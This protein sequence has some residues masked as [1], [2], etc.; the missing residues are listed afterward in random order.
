MKQQLTK[1]EVIQTNRNYF[2]RLMN[3]AEPRAF[4]LNTALASNPFL[5]QKDHFKYIL[6]Q[7][8]DYNQRVQKGIVRD[9][10]EMLSFQHA[11]SML[12]DIAQIDTR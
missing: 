3:E 8:K 10:Y 1:E 4:T 9:P 2:K 12:S 7:L 11:H 6:S 5:K